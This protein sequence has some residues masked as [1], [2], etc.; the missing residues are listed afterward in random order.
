MKSNKL[1]GAILGDLTGQPYEFKYKGDFSEFNIH[2]ERSVITDDTIL[3]LA[4]AA[5]MLGKYESFEDAYRRI[6]QRYINLDCFGKGF[7]EWLSTPYGTVNNSWGNGCL[8][9]VG[10]LMYIEDSLPLI[11]ESVRCSHNHEIS[12]ESIFKLF[13]S[14]KYGVFKTIIVQSSKEITPFKKFEVRADKTI[15]FCLNVCSV[16]YGTKKSIERAVKC[17]GDTD[18][19]ASI[20]GEY[21]N[22]VLQDLTKEDCDYVESKLD[23]FLL[24][25]LYAFNKKF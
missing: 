13:K 17:G 16:T 2:D 11:L 7:Q 23:P 21:Q 12:Y 4:T 15:D 25:I 9:R 1:Y 3:T 18:T 24:D 5:Y 22:F 10:P 19:N 8:M 20:I 6:G 14:Y